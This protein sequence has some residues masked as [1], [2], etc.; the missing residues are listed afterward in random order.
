MHP[1]YVIKTQGGQSAL[2]IT[3]QGDSF[4]KK[5]KRRVFLKKRRVCLMGRPYVNDD[6]TELITKKNSKK[7]IIINES[8]CKYLQI[9]N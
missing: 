9:Y 3:F 6:Y 5:E 7:R 2:L 8:R 4:K 1:L